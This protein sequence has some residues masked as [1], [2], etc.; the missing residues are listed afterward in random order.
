MCDLSLDLGSLKDEDLQSENAGADVDENDGELEEAD[1]R[2]D[3][4]GIL[5]TD[6]DGGNLIETTRRGSRVS[7]SS[8]GRT[9]T[10]RRSSRVGDGLR[11][12][13]VEGFHQSVDDIGT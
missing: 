7:V 13:M 3:C 4:N 9:N 5:D 8:L 10:T 2:I 1:I 11:K 6:S 12:S